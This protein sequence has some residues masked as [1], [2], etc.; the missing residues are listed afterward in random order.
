MFDY[1][2]SVFVIDFF[3]VFERQFRQ[4][5]TSFRREGCYLFLRRVIFW[6]CSC[7][8]LFHWY[9]KHDACVVG[10][11]KF[12]NERVVW[13]TIDL[14]VWFGFSLLPWNAVW[15][16][17]TNFIGQFLI[18]WFGFFFGFFI[19]FFFFLVFETQCGCSERTV[20]DEAVVCNVW[21][22]GLVFSFG[23]FVF[24]TERSRSEKKKN[25]C[26]RAPAESLLW[27]NRCTSRHGAFIQTSRGRTTFRPLSRTLATCS[28]QL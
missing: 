3:L 16:Q 22:L 1:F 11:R 28:L 18:S 20:R 10:V 5:D 23:F 17:R 6:G 24:E 15:L 7:F 19:W 12:S 27:K 13:R 2:R 4:S 8:R 26:E 21:V 25:N 9:S 14:K